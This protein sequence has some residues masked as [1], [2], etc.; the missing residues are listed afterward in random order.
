M[1]KLDPRDRITLEHA[2]LIAMPRYTNFPPLDRT[3][4]RYIV[5]Q[6]GLYLEVHRPWLD[7]VTLVAPSDAPLPYG[8]IVDD[9]VVDFKFTDAELEQAVR[10]FTRL[11][12][13]ALPNEC[14]AWGIWNEHSAALEFWPLQPLQASPGAVSYA[15]PRLPEGLHLAIDFHSHAAAPAFFSPTD[16]HDDAGAVKLAVV[17]GELDTPAPDGAAHLCA[18]GHVIDININISDHVGD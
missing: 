4:H 3:G 2:P 10:E 17:V 14:A 9:D 12:R 13:A 1:T 18:L 16:D 11:A 6:D 5:A 15:R 8:D 7:L